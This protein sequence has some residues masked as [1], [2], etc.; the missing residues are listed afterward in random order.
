MNVVVYAIMA[1]FFTGIISLGIVG[2]IVLI[3]HVLSSEKEAE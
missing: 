1:Y 2:I 3:N